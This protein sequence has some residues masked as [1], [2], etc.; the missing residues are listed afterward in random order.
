M[1]GLAQSELAL[2]SG[3]KIN[4]PSDDP[5]G[6]AK[7]SA[8]STAI[9]KLG[10][11]SK[12]M[13]DVSSKMK[14]ADS[15]LISAHNLLQ[16]ASEVA[17]Q[18]AT[19]TVTADSRAAAAKEVDT[20]FQQLVQIGNTSVGGK[21]IFAGYKNSTPPF[22]Q[23]GNYVSD[24]NVI[25]SEIGAG[26]FTQSNIP[27]DS[28]F[29]AAGGVDIFGALKNLSTA[30]AANDTAGIGSAMDQINAAYSQ[31]EA[32]QAQVGSVENLVSDSQSRLQDDETN[33]K[34]LLSNNEDVDIVQAIGKFQMQ[35]AALTAAR[36]AASKLFDNSL[37]D[38]IK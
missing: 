16:K 12:N 5:A 21:Y 11:Y 10:Q 30:L 2:S 3:K 15:V 37:L 25:Q 22:D 19:G 31:L 1:D 24:S 20:M 34:G 4:K 26:N 29:S 6:T 27:G 28:I 7:V 36:Q 9:S 18:E 32:S 8:L 13:D 33:M 14:L 38:Y 35:S 17:T 23:S